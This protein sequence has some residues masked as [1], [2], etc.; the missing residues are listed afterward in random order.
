M[1]ETFT[2][3]A[4]GGEKNPWRGFLQRIQFGKPILRHQ[5]IHIVANAPT[6][7]APLVPNAFKPINECFLLFFF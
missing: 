3:Q 5:I 6:T 4:A 7:V 2:D 1:V